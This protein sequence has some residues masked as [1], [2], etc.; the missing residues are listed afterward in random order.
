[1]AGHLYS[2]LPREVPGYAEA[3]AAGLTPARPSRPPSRR[4]GTT[5]H[6]AIVQCG[7]VLA[8]ASAVTVVAMFAPG[9]GDQATWAELMIVGV[10]VAGIVAV[11]AAM[12]RFRRILLAELAAGYV[13][14]TFSQGQFWYVDTPGPK[15]GKGLMAWNWDGTWVL[16]R[17]GDVV[18]ESD[19]D[20]EPPG[21]YPSPNRPGHLELWTGTQWTG[22]YA[23]PGGMPS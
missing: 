8:I 10:T 13:T 15:W 21:M 4:P 9:D 20:V 18:S 7:I 22:V 12:R 16:N 6:Q 5:A 14:T 1:M 3:V 2:P 11:T 19:P 23:E 17:A